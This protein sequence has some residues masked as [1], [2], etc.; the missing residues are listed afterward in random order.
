MGD[1]NY[2][3]VNWVLQTVEDNANA[4]CEELLNCCNDYVLIQHALEY[5]RGNA[6]LDLVFSREPDLVSYVRI[7]ENLGNS[8]HNMVAICYC[9]GSFI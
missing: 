6:V 9:H 5:T 4:N 7:I 8:Y 2:P 3:N 1:F